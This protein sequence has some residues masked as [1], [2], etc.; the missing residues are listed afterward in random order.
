MAV[1]GFGKDAA[2]A[3]KLYT[4]PMDGTLSETGGLE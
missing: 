4:Q 3:E 1:T 2:W